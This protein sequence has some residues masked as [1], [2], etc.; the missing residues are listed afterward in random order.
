[1]SGAEAGPAEPEVTPE[2][3]E[4]ISLTLEGCHEMCVFPDPGNDCGACRESTLL[5]Y[6]GQLTPEAEGYRK[7]VAWTEAVGERVGERPEITPLIERIIK[8][9][10]SWMQGAV[11]DLKSAQKCNREYS[12]KI[13]DLEARVAEVVSVPAKAVAA[14][15]DFQAWET[16]DRLQHALWVVHEEVCWSGTVMH[17]PDAEGHFEIT[18]VKPELLAEACPDCRAVHERDSE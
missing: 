17:E 11:D 7:V 8:G 1:M 5:A 13:K 16:I 4:G 12:A 9:R 15:I 3:V 18:K 6:I 14:M 2:R 10:N